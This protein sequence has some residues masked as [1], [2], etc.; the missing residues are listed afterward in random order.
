ESARWGYTALQACTGAAAM[1]CA[2]LLAF[3][4]HGVARLWRLLVFAATASWLVGELFWYLGR[5]PEGGT[6]RPVAVAAY[7]LP[8]VI[9][10]AAMVLLAVSSGGLSTDPDGPLRGSRTITILDGLVAAASFTILVLIAGFGDRT[11]AT[12]PRS[13]NTGVL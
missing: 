9:S 5:A 12:L 8:P 7:F 13:G 10:L 11:G 4:N 6:A 3:R 2:G 1:V